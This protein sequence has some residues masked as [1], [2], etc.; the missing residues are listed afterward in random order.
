MNVLD[1]FLS[2]I[3]PTASEELLGACWS[4][5]FWSVTKIAGCSPGASHDDPAPGKK[6]TGVTAEIMDDLK[7]MLAEAVKEG[8]KQHSGKNRSKI[9]LTTLTS[10]FLR[11]DEDEV[12]RYNGFKSFI[13]ALCCY[14]LLRRSEEPSRRIEIVE[15]LVLALSIPVESI[16]L[17]ITADRKTRPVDDEI[18]SRLTG[19]LVHTGVRRRPRILG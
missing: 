4:W 13:V 8:L 9:I 2:E 12:G 18:V 10:G 3:S 16:S 19:T 15:C 17:A 1:R 11:G 6:A 5:V 7:R 14:H